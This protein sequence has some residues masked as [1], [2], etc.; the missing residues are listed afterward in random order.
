MADKSPN[1]LFRLGQVVCGEMAVFTVPLAGIA[2]A[3]GAPYVALR[4]CAL[5]VVLCIAYFVFKHLWLGWIIDANGER[6]KV[7][8]RDRYGVLT[9]QTTHAQRRSEASNLATIRRR[10]IVGSVTVALTC[11]A[12]A[13]SWW[14]RPD[15]KLPVM[16]LSVIGLPTA[17]LAAKE[18]AFE[19]LYLAGFQYMKGARVLDPKPSRPGFDQVVSQHAHGH[20]RLASEA[21][22]IKHLNSRR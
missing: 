8:A 11:G 14:D 6:Q 9:T 5:T 3:Q 16:L 1:E 19:L 13:Y 17:L 20:A 21:E 12:M 2:Y 18:L 22:A 15:L 10:A 7:M 4:V